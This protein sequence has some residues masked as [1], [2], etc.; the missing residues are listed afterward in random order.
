MSKPSET[1]R[2]VLK[3]LIG[4]ILSLILTL[5]AF[6]AVMLHTGSNHELLA[7]EVLVPLV[8]GL[9]VVQLVVQLTFF[10]HLTHESRPRWNLIAFLFML[11]VLVIVVLGSLWIMQNLNYNMMPED[12]NEYMK[13]HPGSF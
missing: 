3:Y 2:Q 4:F 5:A 8:I 7:H 1:K 10:L 11:L 6:Y 13:E 9:A 12:I